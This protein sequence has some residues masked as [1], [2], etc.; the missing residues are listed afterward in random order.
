MALEY[1]QGWRPH[2]VWATCVSSWSNSQY[3]YF[4]LCLARSSCISFYA[5]CLWFCHQAP[6]NRACLSSLHL[7]FRILYFYGVPLRLFFPGLN[8]HSSLILSLY[9][10]CFCPLITLTALCWNVSCSSLPLLYWAAPCNCTRCASS[11]LSSGIN[12]PPNSVHDAISWFCDKS[13]FLTHIQV[14][15]LEE[16]EV[17]SPKAQGCNL[18]FCSL[19]SFQD[20]EFHCLMGTAAKAAF[21]THISNK[22]LIL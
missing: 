4:S 1:L 13:L 3:K 8:S 21:S 22:P 15:V 10:R 12:T 14:G 16:A 5:L 9:W 6:Q 20:P 2:N 17:C 19:S 18:A 11:V 7:P